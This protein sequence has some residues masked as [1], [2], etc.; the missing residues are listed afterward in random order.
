MTA[1]PRRYNRHM[2]FAVVAVLLAACAS[3]PPPPPSTPA[4]AAPVAPVASVPPADARPLSN[5]EVSRKSHELLDAIDR[6][7]TARVEPLLATAYAHFEGG[8]PLTR[9]DELTALAK[10]KPGGPSIAKRVWSDEHITATPNDAV[11]IGKATETQGGNDKHGGYKFVGW[12]TL[13]WV[14]E[15]GA[16]KVRLWTWQRAG[17]SAA[18]DFWN[19]VYRNDSGFEKRPNQLLVEIT[20]G[21]K[22]GTALDLAMGQGRNALYL[23]QLGWKVTGVDFALEGVQIARAE[24]EKRKLPLTSVMADID[25]WD[26][27]TNRWDLVSMIYPGDNHEPWIE[28]AKRA[29][30]KDGLFVLEFFA[31]DPDDPDD[32]GYRPGQL[33]KMFSGPDFQV[34]RDDT[35]EGTPDWAVDHAT[36]VRFVARKV[37]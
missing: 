1:P 2:R 5:E 26:F 14:R 3:S 10:R 8:K 18:P 11:F 33:A 30:K 31:A 34:V 7:E 12:Y 32:G 6:G 22:P 4:P 25:T 27:G 29:L 9:D 24:A 21:K 16:W 36:L 35:F 17:K 28:K 19:D 23:A 20:N 15:G 13:A 37:R